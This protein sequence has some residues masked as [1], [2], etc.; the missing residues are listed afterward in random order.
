[1]TRPP[2]PADRRVHEQIKI[3]KNKG[4]RRGGR[5][6]QIRETVQPETERC[7][8]KKPAAP[9]SG[10][11]REVGSGGVFQIKDNLRV[12]CA[13]CAPGRLLSSVD[14]SFWECGYQ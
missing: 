2:I 14:I 13:A 3:F 1:M 12:H 4:H 9:E 7:N 11:Q 8:G 5:A 10:K 6:D